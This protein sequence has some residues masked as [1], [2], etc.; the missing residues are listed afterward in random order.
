[1]VPRPAGLSPVPGAGPGQVARFAKRAIDARWQGRQFCAP[2]PCGTARTLSGRILPRHVGPARPL[3]TPWRAGRSGSHAPCGSSS[4]PPCAARWFSP[5]VPRTPPTSVEPTEPEASAAIK[6]IAPGFPIVQALTQI[7]GAKNLIG[8]YPV[9]KP[10]PL[11]LALAR[12][13]EVAALWTICKSAQA[14]AKVAAHTKHRAERFPHRPA[15]RRHQRRDRRASRYARQHHVAGCGL[16]PPNLPITPG[17]GTD[18]GVGL[19]TPGHPLVVRTGSNAGAVRIPPGGF[20]AT[21]PHFDRGAPARLPE[22]VRGNRRAGLRA[23]LRD[24]RVQR[25]QRALPE[26][27]HRRDRRLLRRRPTHCRSSSTFGDPAIAHVAVNEGSN[28]GGFEILP[29]ATAGG[30]QPARAR[31]R[32]VLHQRRSVRCSMVDC[33]ASRPR[34]LNTLAA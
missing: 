23:V 13:A 9:T 27:Y 33:G 4:L 20:T 25:E 2:A 1:M 19:F 16:P 24:R 29:T 6:C 17:T 30:L 34:R 3:G 28:P 11:A 21:D 5:A 26:R 31:L 7:S 22:P 12:V 32:A 14:Q 18:F 8:L 10:K 15:D